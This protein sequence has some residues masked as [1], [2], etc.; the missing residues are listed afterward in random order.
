MNS[1]RDSS[2]FSRHRQLRLPPFSPSLDYLKFDKSLPKYGD[3]RVALRL[4]PPHGTL[5]TIH[6]NNRTLFPQPEN[7]VVLGYHIVKEHYLYY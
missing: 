6:A 7:C 2:T 5:S 4:N 1:K 3:V